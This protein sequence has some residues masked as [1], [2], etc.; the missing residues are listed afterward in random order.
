MNCDI[1]VSVI[2]PIYNASDYL[3]PALDSVIYQSLRE[4]EI[5]C[6]DDG[7][8][9][10]SLEILKEYQ[11]NDDRVRI[12][13]EANAGPGLARNNGIG[14]ARG[15][16]ITFLDA[17]DFYEPNFLEL[18]YARA[19]EDK[20]DIVISGYDIYNSHR[21]IFVKT[22]EGD[23][24]EIY[25]GGKVSSKSEHP[26]EILTSTTGSAWNKMFRR[27]FL[28]DKEIKFLPDVK[29]YED[30]Y[31]T[32]TALALA[33]RIAR[34]PE[35]LLHHRIHSEQ[36]RTKVIRKNYLQI[37]GVFIKIKESLMKRG[38]YAP[39]FISYLN[40]SV[41]RCYKLYNILPRDSKENLWKLLRDELVEELGWTERELSD[42]ESE[43]LYSFVANV[44]MYTHDQ[45]RKKCQR[46]VKEPSQKT[47]QTL[48]NFKFRKKLKNFF[49]G[50]LK[51]KKKEK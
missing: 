11:K 42:F 43:E 48:K 28:I 18:L 40:L 10:C 25:D 3:R 27:S 26:D 15:E 1:K 47:T 5:I 41:S 24:V 38:M 34:V 7:S 39:L 21:A 51:K 13:T 31:F 16:Y 6:I 14:K 32:V 19:L 22:D 12:V 33:E 20:L 4:I 46:G 44:E 30:V 2:I 8:T 49:F 37:P 17:D 9:D 50:F 35:I 23:H 36:S 45:Y 29:I